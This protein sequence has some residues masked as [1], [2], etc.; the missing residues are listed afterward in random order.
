M[1]CGFR[2]PLSRRSQRSHE[3]PEEQSVD[4]SSTESTTSAV[5]LGLVIV[6]ME[7]DKI[8]HQRSA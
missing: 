1:S 7:L 6:M 8:R 5:A 4:K 3:E 2:A